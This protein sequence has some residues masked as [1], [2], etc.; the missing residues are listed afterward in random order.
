MPDGNRDR[1]CPD[2]KIRT[3]FKSSKDSE[4]YSDLYFRGAIKG[5]K[6][7]RHKGVKAT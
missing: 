5:V 3:G 1:Q 4:R 2:I 7:Q 6:A